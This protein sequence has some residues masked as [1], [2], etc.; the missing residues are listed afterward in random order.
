MDIDMNIYHGELRARQRRVDA[1]REARVAAGAYDGVPNVQQLLAGRDVLVTGG[2]GF[3]GRV[4]LEKLL[5]SCPDIGTVFLL[6]RA[7]RGVPPEERVAGIVNVPLFDQL[8]REQPTAI[9]KLVPVAGDCAELGLGLSPEDRAMLQDRVFIVFHGA[10]SVRFDDPVRK[11]VL[12]NTRGAREV[13]ALC[14]GMRQLQ[15]LVYI[16]TA[17]TNTNLRRIEERLYP[18]ELDWR[19]V[20]SAV[21][22][23]DTA[24]TMDL[25]GHKLIGF[26]PNTYTFSKALAEQV[27]ADAAATLPVVIVRPSIVVGAVKEPLPGWLDNLN[28]PASMWAAVNMGVLR[29]SK[30]SKKDALLD[31]MP[32]D[33][34]TKATVVTAWASATKQLESDGTT[35]PVVNAALSDVHPVSDA[36]CLAIYKEVQRSVPFSSAIRYP[37]F[38]QYN[39]WLQYAA[40][41]LVYHLMFGL[42]VDGL[43]RLSGQKPRLMK[44]YRKIASATVALQ[45]I[46]DKVFTFETYKFWD[47]QRLMHPDDVKTFEFDLDSLEP[48]KDALNQLIGI[49]HYVLKGKLDKERGLRHID[50][51]FWMEIGFYVSLVAILIYLYLPI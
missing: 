40:I 39:N 42:F 11:A 5:R 25:L 8:R 24:N 44:V 48:R 16:S 13:A 28:S 21:E 12:L 14:A 6:L 34:V 15:S 43:L 38:A 50:R 46:T 17:Y 1:G 51:L 23:A 2:S 9:S 31:W 30:L 22:N 47:L 49:W 41:H 36:C 18:T 37:V 27:M 3:L 35:V 29:V 26:H 33:I 32:V 19:T 20:I 10:A 7:K 45:P 4:L